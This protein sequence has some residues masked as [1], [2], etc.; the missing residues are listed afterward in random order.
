MIYLIIRLN[1]NLM[2]KNKLFIYILIILSSKNK[3]IKKKIRNNQNTM[4]NSGLFY[5]N[6]VYILSFLFVLNV[7]G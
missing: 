3:Y 5:C 7:C 4:S 6:E 1:N 2:I